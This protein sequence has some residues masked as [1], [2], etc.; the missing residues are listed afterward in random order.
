[1]E[2]PSFF[3][4][5]RHIQWVLCR[6]WILRWSFLKKDKQ[7]GLG[8]ACHWLSTRVRCLNALKS[9]EKPTLYPSVLGCGERYWHSVGCYWH[10]I[11]SSHLAQGH[12]AELLS[13]ACDQRSF[14]LMYQHFAFLG[15]SCERVHKENN[16]RTRIVPR[17]DN[18][19]HWLTSFTLL[20][21]VV[22]I[23]KP[24]TIWCFPI[25]FSN[26]FV[27]L[28]CW[29]FFSGATWWSF[30]CIYYCCFFA[31][32]KFAESKESCSLGQCN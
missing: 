10:V 28:S 27:I 19:L 8:F 26:L 6:R 18:V 12:E 5:E 2:C 17:L 29:Y 21:S 13:A 1:M 16:S 4:P 32:N 20:L 31:R 3:A 9:F 15:C 25:T 22:N 24:R 11:F 7:K 14:G 30:L 23:M